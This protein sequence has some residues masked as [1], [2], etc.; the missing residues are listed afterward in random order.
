MTGMRA[1]L[2]SWDWAGPSAALA[3]RLAAILPP[4]WSIAKVAA[5]VEFLYALRTYDAGE[6]ANYARSPTSNPY[7]ARVHDFEQIT[8]GSNPYLLARKV[9]DLTVQYRGKNGCEEIRWREPPHYV[10]DSETGR[11]HLFAEGEVVL[12][13]RRLSGPLSAFPI[14]DRC[15]DS[16]KHGWAP[17]E[18]PTSVNE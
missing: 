5:F 12:E 8:C 9:S 14:W 6:L 4:R 7:R 10:I 17:G 18:S 15:S 11:A 1:W 3:D 16:Y 2:I 13:R